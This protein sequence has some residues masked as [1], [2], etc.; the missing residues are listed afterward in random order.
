MN[1]LPTAEDVDN[2]GA[3]D[4]TS[5]TDATWLS[6]SN[7]AMTMDM[8]SGGQYLMSAAANGAAG[9][10]WVNMNPTSATGGSGYTIE[11]LLKIDS[12]VSGTKYALNLQAGTHDTSMYN[13]S[14]NFNTSGIYW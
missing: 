13:A 5:S 14:P 12:Q 6:L 11:A 1:A 7:G 2:S 4:F 3:V 10:A 9:D 8:T